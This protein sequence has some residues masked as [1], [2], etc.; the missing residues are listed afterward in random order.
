MENGGGIKLFNYRPMVMCALSLI[1]GIVVGGL[2]VQNNI[3]GAI[4]LLVLIFAIAIYYRFSNLIGF[5]LKHGVCVCFAVLFLVYGFGAVS[6]KTITFKPYSNNAVSISASGTIVE[7]GQ[8][9]LASNLKATYYNSNENKIMHDQPLSGVYYLYF[10]DDYAE[11]KNLEVGDDIVFSG[12]I[13]FNKSVTKN[14]EIN[15][16]LFSSGVYGSIYLSYNDIAKTGTYTKTETF[17]FLKNGA[18]NFFKQNLGELEANVAYAMVFGEK[19]GLGELYQDFKLSGMAHL[20][21]VSGLH[22][23]F[24]VVILTFICSILHLKSKTKFFV[25]ISVLFVYAWVCGF[26]TSVTRALIMTA[27][28]MLSLLVAKQYD[29]L[30]ALGFA[31]IIILLIRP[32]DLFSLGFKLSFCAVLGIILMA[33]PLTRLFAKFLGEKFGGAVAVTT[34]ATIGTLP[35]LITIYS[36]V[37]SLS[38]LANLIAVPIASAAYMSL[39]VFSIIVVVLPF[40]RFILAVPQVLIKALIYI[41]KI[42]AGLDRAFVEFMPDKLLVLAVLVLAFM[43]SDYVFINKKAKRAFGLALAV[44]LMFSAGIYAF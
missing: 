18:K 9:L 28:L 22:V 4:I 32:L 44:L 15:T 21:A 39:M 10:A 30:S 41:A 27:C 7:S 1:L 12:T 40:L 6:I 43:V 11:S 35:I 42:T 34:S 19:E 37:S 16:A 38:I 23:G 31:A 14:G 3:F 24:F 36:R 29:S 33:K 13:S 25:V 17:D 20:L 5:I 2:F 8:H 26:T